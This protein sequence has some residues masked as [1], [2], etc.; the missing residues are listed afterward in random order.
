ME[1]TSRGDLVR[2]N[3]EGDSLRHPPVVLEAVT[4]PVIE[5]RHGPL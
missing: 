5:S 4:F 3:I 2:K 1:D